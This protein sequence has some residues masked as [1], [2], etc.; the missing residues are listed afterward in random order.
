MAETTTILSVGIDIGTSTTQVIFSRLSFENAS[1]YF[2]IP[3][4]SI[5]EKKVVYKSQIYNTPLKTSCLIDGERIREIVDREFGRAGYTRAD[6]GTGAVIV[7]GE[8][9]RKENSEIVLQELS[10]FSGE[11]VVSTAGPDL[12]AII[13]GKGSGACEY[14]RKQ[15]CRVVNIDVGGGT[16]NAVVFDCGEV[17]ARGCL[18]I[19]GRQITYDKN[20]RIDY[21]SPSAEK[22]AHHYGIPV[23]TGQ[24][25]EYQNVCKVAERMA[26]LLW[27]WISG[28]GNPLLEQIKTAGSSAFFPGKVDRVCFSGGVGLCVEEAG[29]SEWN[30]YGDIGILLGDAIRRNGKYTEDYVLCPKETI[31]ATV[32]GAGSYTTSVSGSTISYSKDMFPLKNVPVFR[33]EKWEEEKCFLGEYEFLTERIRWFQSQIDSKLIA[34]SLEGEKAP[35]YERTKKLAYALTKA[36]ES[37]LDEDMPFVII[38]EED[39]AKALGVFIRQYRQNPKRDLVCI[40]SIRAMQDDYV[41]LGH[42]MMNGLVIPLVVKTLI[43]G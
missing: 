6:I 31:R 33:L 42:P 26:D 9:A 32:I 21:I 16:S 28:Q 41:D 15:K 22:I 19:G 7:T 38:V 39:I 10:D 13:A 37:V 14:S 43:I 4:I 1:G 20:G 24:K 2:T 12:E 8:S 23:Y 29:N 34:L 25:S 36:L 17:S 3:H 30:R 40:D 27:Q 11:F 35:S 5:T 18:D